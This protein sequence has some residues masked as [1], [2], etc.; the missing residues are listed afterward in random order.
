MMAMMASSSSHNNHHSH[1][2][3]AGGGDAAT[4]LRP[5]EAQL[6]WAQFH[7][8]RRAVGVRASVEALHQSPATWEQ[9]PGSVP[10]DG[11]S[12]SSSSSSSGGGSQHSSNT[13]SS[14]TRRTRALLKE[15]RKRRPAISRGRRA[16]LRVSRRSY[17]R[18]REIILKQG[19]QGMTMM[20]SSSGS[21]SDSSSSSSEG[22]SKNN[23][24]DHHHDHQNHE[25]GGDEESDVHEDAL[26]EIFLVQSSRW[27]QQQRRRRNND[28]KLR[29][30][31][32]RRNPQKDESFKR[33]QAACHAMMMNLAAPPKHSI[34]IPTRKWTRTVDPAAALDDEYLD[35]KWGIRRRQD[36]GGDHASNPAFGSND[37]HHHHLAPMDRGASWMMHLPKGQS[38]ARENP[39]YHDP[40]LALPPSAGS[41]QWYAGGSDSQESSVASTLALQAPGA[42]KFNMLVALV[43]Q[44][45]IQRHHDQHQDQH[46]HQHHHEGL[47][48]RQDEDGKELLELQHDPGMSEFH[49]RPSMEGLQRTPYLPHHSSSNEMATTTTTVVRRSHYVPRMR[50]RDFVPEGTSAEDVEELERSLMDGKGIPPKM[51]LRGFLGAATDGDPPSSTSRRKSRTQELAESYEASKHQGNKDRQL[52]KTR[53]MAQSLEGININNSKHPKMRLRPNY[54]FRNGEDEE[55]KLSDDSI[56]ATEDG[57]PR[58]HSHALSGK[59]DQS[60]E[61]DSSGDGLNR[62]TRH[63][64]ALSGPFSGPDVTQEESHLQTR[65]SMS[66]ESIGENAVASQDE[67]ARMSHHEDKSGLLQDP[68]RRKPHPMSDRFV[69]AMQAS[70]QSPQ[71]AH[72]MVKPLPPG[73]CCSRCAKPSPVASTSTNTFPFTGRESTG[74]EGDFFAQVRSINAKVSV[75]S[76]RVSDFFSHL[77]QTND[78]STTEHPA[79]ENIAK[80]SSI[81]TDVTRSATGSHRVSDFFAKVRQS[82][83]K[84]EQHQPQSTSQT[85]DVPLEETDFFAQVREMIA[86]SDDDEES[87]AQRVSDFFAQVR[88]M[89]NEMEEDE[90]VDAQDDSSP[91][92]E[93]CQVEDIEERVES[94]S[95]SLSP[96]HGAEIRISES[97]SPARASNANV[98]TAK[99]D[100]FDDDSKSEHSAISELWNRGRTSFNSFASSLNAISEK[101]AKVSVNPINQGR[102]S[103]TRMPGRVGGFLQK[104]QGQKEQ[105]QEILRAQLAEEEGGEQHMHVSAAKDGGEKSNDSSNIPTQNE[106]DYSGENDLEAMA[107]YRRSQEMKRLSSP[108]DGDTSSHSSFHVLPVDIREVVKRQGSSPPKNTRQVSTSP[109]RAVGHPSTSNTKEILPQ[110]KQRPPLSSPGRDTSVEGNLNADLAASALSRPSTG[111][112]SRVSVTSSAFE[113]LLPENYREAH[114]RVLHGSPLLGNVEQGIIDTD[115]TT[116]DAS[117]SGM[118]PQLLA[119]MMLSPDLLQKRLHQAVRAVE[120][121][122]WGQV[123]YLLNANP[124]LAEMCELTTNQYLLHKVAFFGFSA[125]RKLCESLMEM[126]PS[127]IY[128]FDHDGNVPL[129]LAAAAGHMKMIRMLGEKFGSGAS[130]RNEDGMLPLHFTIASYA[131]YKGQYDQDEEDEDDPSPLR[132]IKTVLKFFPEAVAIGDNDG[133]LPIHV[134]AECLSGGFGVDVIYLLLDEADRQLQDPDGA[135]FH[136]KVKLKDIVSDDISASTMPSDG[137]IESL[138]DE[139]IHCI[140]VKNDFGETPVL[141]AVRH[142]RGWDVIEA[143]V[144][145]PGGQK[146]ALYEDAGKNNVLHLLVGEYQDP[147][148][149]MSILKIV[150]KTATMRN[151]DGMLPI[152]VRTPISLCTELDV[153]CTYL[154]MYCRLLVFSSCQRRLSLRWPWLISH[155]T[156]M[157]RIS[158]NSATIMVVAG[159]S[160]FANA[161]TTMWTLFNR[162]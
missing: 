112:P 137:E 162:S 20:L 58:R 133:N 17:E 29:R 26:N 156:L 67:A 96:E 43:Q 27:K 40:S 101:T 110:H 120:E 65:V 72:I 87:A 36:H 5:T 49:T 34:V 157:T 97:A 81:S 123:E 70:Q 12:S 143:L 73:T 119:S 33:F 71:R 44:R 30:L 62:P 142:R 52:S 4:V 11:N 103:A 7:H 106:L 53:Q 76:A 130:I 48:R 80:Q 117:N 15:I 35:P 22:S 56:A 95:V 154:C 79:T 141:A 24:N 37:N 125:P 78:A 89:S 128:K 23:E 122:H 86:T 57:P 104:L 3:P 60:G 9:V 93:E 121:R 118:N 55:K 98:A 135:R 131:E 149:A 99:T 68:P 94:A 45:M 25:G 147:A 18:R 88:E 32:R 51:K 84:T 42:H 140:M 115:G 146:A 77:R 100:S 75:G 6:R 161:M 66:A 54:E 132:V 91:L 153:A 114:E 19:Y 138:L 134:A 151:S 102:I 124:W 16:L 150:P 61:G 1:A 155:L 145:G 158:L 127:A 63:P 159:G 113:N 41:Y 139:D 8:K 90:N 46:Q 10:E 59:F 83:P 69:E 144:S 38:S 31:R 82:N 85:D 126:F 129:H 74:A 116:S 107:A 160:W 64:H 2:T 13:T 39:Y 105:E 28:Q 50:L 148:A 136:N 108:Q 111:S 152:E 47:N 21:T 14:S 109:Q 92:C